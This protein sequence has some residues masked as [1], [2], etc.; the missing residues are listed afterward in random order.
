MLGTFY[1]LILLMTLEVD[2]A[3]LITLIKSRKVQREPP[4]F[5]SQASAISL[6][7]M[8]TWKRT[9]CD[10]YKSEG[11]LKLTEIILSFGENGQKCQMLFNS[12]Q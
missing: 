2:I 4:G 11:C 8:S 6:L 7:S 12:N 9:A 5:S 1:Q 3:L 10:Y